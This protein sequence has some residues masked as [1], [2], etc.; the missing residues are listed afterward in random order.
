MSWQGVPA[1]PVVGE[2]LVTDAEEFQE[3]L[4]HHVAIHRPEAIAPAFEALSSVVDEI[5]P[6]ELET[7]TRARDLVLAIAGASA[8]DAVHVAAMERRGI[9][10][11]F[12]FDRGFDAFPGIRRLV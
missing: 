10:T 5:L 7:V 2:R 6:I 4:H 11:I 3:I 1:P 9:Q 8:R 12:T